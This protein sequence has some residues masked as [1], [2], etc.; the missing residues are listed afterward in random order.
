MRIHLSLLLLGSLVSTDVL[1]EACDVMTRSSSEAVKPVEQHTCYSFD[2]MPDNAVAWSCS[3]ESKEML[4]SE[5]RQVAQCQEGSVGRCTAPLTQESLANPRSG[6]RGEQTTRPAVPKD[7]R[8]VTHYY[9]TADLGQA[10]IDCKN[11]SG[12]WQMR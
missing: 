5:K 12:E 1:A 6:G 2:G 8:V 10:Q 9:S 7:A 3:N 11:N 4:N